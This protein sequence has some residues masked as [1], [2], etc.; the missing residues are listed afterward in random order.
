MEPSHATHGALTLVS[1]RGGLHVAGC[2]WFLTWINACSSCPK[3]CEVLEAAWGQWRRSQA[4][5]LKGIQ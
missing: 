5:G 1:W 4:T 2:M 3:P